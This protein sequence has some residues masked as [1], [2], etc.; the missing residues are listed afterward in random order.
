MGLRQEHYSHLLKKPQTQ[1]KWFEEDLERVLCGHA[2]KIIQAD[3]SVSP[4]NGRSVL[5]KGAGPKTLIQNGAPLPAQSIMVRASAV[6]P[7]GFDERIPIASDLLFWIEVLSSGGKFGY[8]EGVYA[9]Y[10][11][12]EHNVSKQYAAMLN[13]MEKSYHIIAEKFPDYKKICETSMSSMGVERS[14]V[15]AFIESVPYAPDEIR[16]LGE[17]GYIKL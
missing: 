1:V 17:E 15:P 9:N 16:G 2:V 3:G 4:N 7:H 14:E 6:P 5:R 10:R 12:H 8:I 11:C 13:D